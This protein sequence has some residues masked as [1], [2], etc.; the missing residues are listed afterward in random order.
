MQ[1]SHSRIAC[2][3]QCPL[4][5]KFTY[6]E[7]PVLE[8]PEGIEAFLGGVVHE[9]LERLYNLYNAGKTVERASLLEHF[10]D[11]WDKR[12]PRDVRIV[13][14]EL[15]AD[16]YRR[17][18]LR[19][20]ALY[21]DHYHPFDQGITVAT[22][23]RLSFGIGGAEGPTLVGFIDRLV[24]TE[25]GAFEIHDYKTS[26]RLPSARALE[27]DRQLALYE[28]GLRRTWP[29]PVEEVELV[30]HY[31]R[32]DSELRSS[33]SAEDLVRV[34]E[35]TLGSIEHIERSLEAGHF[36][37]RQ[38]SLCP[39]CDFRPLCPVYAHEETTTGMSAEEFRADQGVALVD[40]YAA[41]DEQEK[42]ARARKQALRRLIIELA[43]EK[44]Y[45]R[46][47]GSSHQVTVSRK[48]RSSW[49]SASNEPQAYAEVIGLLRESG[50]WE[51]VAE[52]SPTRLDHLLQESGIPEGVEEQLTRFCR[53][54]EQHTVR[55]SRRRDLDD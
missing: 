9:S 10:G 44:D 7:K 12:L 43:A 6:I 35:D 1:Y 19:C 24:R 50:L 31:L 34:E 48:T 4:K 39:W 15:D 45:Q 16:D 41:V 49:P 46:L 29:E 2:F 32:F 30:W 20:L 36:P 21:Y 53:E 52:L 23:N 11:E 5:F 38:G 26:A 27:T 17:V 14:R 13:R 28:L 40:E 42:E 18:G 8:A 55:L 54:K 37:P 47:V 22:E 51:H 33:R 25:R 3:E